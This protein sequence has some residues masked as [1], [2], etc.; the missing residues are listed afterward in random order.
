MASLVG[1]FAASHGPLLARDWHKLPAPLQQRFTAAYHAVGERLTAARPDLLVAV[2]TDHWTNFFLDNWPSFCIGV[3]S[4]H[5]GPPEPFLKDFP[6]DLRG[7]AEFGK[8][9]F[10]TAIRGGFDPSI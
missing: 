9:L 4:A 8:H 7:D 2:A 5:D 1:I 3:G 10:A 6:H